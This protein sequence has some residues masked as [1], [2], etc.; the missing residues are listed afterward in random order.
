[1]LNIKEAPIIEPDLCFSVPL[2]IYARTR[3]DFEEIY[4]QRQLSCCFIGDLLHKCGSKQAIGKGSR[5]R[6]DMSE[7]GRQR[8]SDSISESSITITENRLLV[9]PESIVADRKIILISE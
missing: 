2:K 9:G 5:F 1:M 8:S 3:L 7:E 4:F 6:I